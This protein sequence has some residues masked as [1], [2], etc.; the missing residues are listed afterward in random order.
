MD[1]TLFTLIDR[2]DADGIYRFQYPTYLQQYLPKDRH[3]ILRDIMEREM[4]PAQF[5]AARI[6]RGMVWADLFEASV[7]RGADGQWEGRINM[8]KA[9]HMPGVE[10]AKELAALKTLFLA[11]RSWVAEA[12]TERRDVQLCNNRDGGGRVYASW[13]ARV[14]DPNEAG[15]MSQHASMT[16][17]LDKLIPELE[18]T[19]WTRQVAL[20]L[21]KIGPWSW[22]TIGEEQLYP[23]GERPLENHR[24]EEHRLKAVA[25]MATKGQAPRRAA[26]P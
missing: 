13:S 10:P 9:L 18:L 2:A 4:R 19:E 14:T 24:R 17:Q 25:E 8:A 23:E 6:R 21:G 5:V 20:S 7:Q 16:A 22:W 15:K 11:I 12:P 1:D 3:G 26:A